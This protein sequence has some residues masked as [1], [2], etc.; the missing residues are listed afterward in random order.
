V[1]RGVEEVVASSSQ[2]SEIIEQV[3]SNAD[4][5][6]VVSVGMSSQSEGAQTIA[7]SM[8]AL[9]AAA[10]RSVESAEEFGRTA[11]ELARASQTL[12]G[13]VEA[14]TLRK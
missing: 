14:F 8:G 4:R 2:M 3:S 7:D 12:R 1:R 13:S 6:R 10:K 11:S 5:Y 9:V